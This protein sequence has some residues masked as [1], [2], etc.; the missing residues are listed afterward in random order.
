MAGYRI[1]PSPDFYNGS[2]IAPIEI[3]GVGPNEFEVEK[4]FWIEPEI[5]ARQN[6]EA[7]HQETSANQQH[8]RQSNFGDYENGAKLAMPKPAP[9]A[10]ARACEVRLHIAAN[11]MQRGCKAAQDGAQKCD[12]ER[13]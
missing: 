1:F 13:Q 7:A 6:K 11:D 8:D 5:H 12:A 4:I 2:R 10:R 9:R 3:V